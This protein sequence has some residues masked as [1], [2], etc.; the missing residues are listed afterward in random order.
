M[1]LRSSR[2]RPSNVGGISLSC[3][4]EKAVFCIRHGVQKRMKDEKIE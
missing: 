1:V 4:A 3:E 2:G